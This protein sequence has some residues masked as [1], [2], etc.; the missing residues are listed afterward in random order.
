M[1]SATGCD[2]GEVALQ[3]QSPAAR[4]SVT[5]TLRRVHVE[6]TTG[7]PCRCAV[8]AVVALDLSRWPDR[9]AVSPM[10]IGSRR[11][12]PA[13]S[14]RRFGVD[15]HVLHA[16]TYPRRPGMHHMSLRQLSLFSARRRRTVSRD[17]LSCVV[18]LTSASASSSS[19]QR[20]GPPRSAGGRHQQSFLLAGACVR[21]DEALAQ[22]VRASAPLPY[23]SPPPRALRV[24]RRKNA[25]LQTGRGLVPRP[26]R[27]RRSRIAIV[28]RTELSINL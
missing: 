2:I 14:V 7:S 21:S 10:L 9:Q 5:F 28:D 4:R 27:L 18:T 22:A 12:P 19:V 23:R 24:A 6:E 16:A 17:R 8:L 13:A 11:A 3:S 15:R 25:N 26:D 1:R 20:R